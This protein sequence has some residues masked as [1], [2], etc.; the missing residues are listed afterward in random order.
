MKS[1]AQREGLAHLG[2]ERLFDVGIRLRVP[3]DSLGVLA[4]RLD[5]AAIDH[6]L[7][8][9]RLAGLALASGSH[10]ITLAVSLGTTDDVAAE[11]AR[12][13][14][15]VALVARLVQDLAE[16]LPGLCELPAA[17]SDE[18]VVAA[19]VLDG[20]HPGSTPAS[21]GVAVSTIRELVAVAG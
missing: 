6:P 21:A 9:V 15:G 4:A 14:D 7:S 8:G 5:A 1:H 19:A 17:G 20:L 16:F 13:K 2:L 10:G 12:A 18:A 3:H 11:G